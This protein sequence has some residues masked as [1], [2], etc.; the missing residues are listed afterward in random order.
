M[1]LHPSAT[2]SWFSHRCLRQ[3][4]SSLT[5]V[6]LVLAAS[7]VTLDTPVCKA[8]HKESLSLGEAVAKQSIIQQRYQSMA[9][10][11]IAASAAAGVERE[12]RVRASYRPESVTAI[13]EA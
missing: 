9:S 4:Q 7:G 6:H 8:A 5:R 11:I 2:M 13:V 1:C 12:Q 10:A 3:Q